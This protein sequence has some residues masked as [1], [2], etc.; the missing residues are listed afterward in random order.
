M[1]QEDRGQI[2]FHGKSD[3]IPLV[4]VIGVLLFLGAIV[5]GVTGVS[6]ILLAAA[7]ILLSTAFLYRLLKRQKG[8]RLILNDRGITCYKYPGYLASL[9]KYEMKWEEVQSVKEDDLG[10]SESPGPSCLRFRSAGHA[11]SVTADEV[12]D[13]VGLIAAVYRYIPE[14]MKLDCRRSLSASN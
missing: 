4:G 9:H 6:P 3:W 12:E 10:T 5:G 1:V 14:K 13:Y 7:G 8:L 2:E 11:F